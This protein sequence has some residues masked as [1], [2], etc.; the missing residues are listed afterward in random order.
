MYTQIHLWPSLA[1]PDYRRWSFEKLRLVRNSSLY[2]TSSHSQ[3]AMTLVEKSPKLLK[4]RLDVYANNCSHKLQ[5]I[6]SRSW[7][8]LVIRIGSW[9]R[10][11]KNCRR[12]CKLSSKG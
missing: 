1:C 11:N 9:Q 3:I 12:R 2:E 10:R 5:T 6:I 7:L 8:W 4:I